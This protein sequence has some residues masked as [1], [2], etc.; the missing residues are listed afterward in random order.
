[1]LDAVRDSHHLSIT[2]GYHGNGEV[3]TTR[4]LYVVTADSFTGFQR[5]T[6]R[7]V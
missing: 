6:G 7:A 3:W 5:D 1:M 4:F 2:S